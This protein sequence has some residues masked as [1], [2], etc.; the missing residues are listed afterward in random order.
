VSTRDIGFARRRLPKASRAVVAAGV[1]ALSLAAW[2]QPTPDQIARSL[3]E[4]E[5]RASVCGLSTAPIET[6]LDRYIRRSEA[7][8]LQAQHLR[9]E[10]LAG[11]AE[12]ERIFGRHV[13][14]DNVAAETADLIAKTDRYGLRP[15]GLPSR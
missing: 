4:M 12:Y 10:M 8:T 11:R 9:E 14:C 2:A 15:S 7:G 13:D 5:W 1:I 6:T 3:G